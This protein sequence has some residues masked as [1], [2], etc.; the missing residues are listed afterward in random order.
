MKCALITGITG[1]DGSYLTELLLEKG[2]VV[3]GIIRRAS[4]F[5][6]DRIEHL[7]QDIHSCSAR[8]VLHYGDLTDGTGL[9]RLLEQVSPQEVY[10]LGAQSHVRIS[11]DQ[12]EYTA[13]AVAVGTLRL[14]EAVRDF[15]QRTGQKIKYYQAGSS[16]MFG[17]VKEIPQQE[18]TPFYPRSPYGV[19][20]VFAHWQTINYREAY[21]LFACNGILF[22]HESP[23]RGETF[24]TRKITRAAARI[25]LGLQE[26]LYLGNLEA[27]RDWGFAGDYVEAMWRMLQQAE[28]DDYII[29]TG[30]THSVR[31]FLERVFDQLNLKWQDFVEKDERYFRPTEV[32]ILLGDASKAKRQLG[33]NPTVSLEQLVIMMVEHDLELARQEKTLKDAGHTTQHRRVFGK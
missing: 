22:N 23:R 4:T 32:D 11:F 20:K 21:G 31:E 30:K 27:K 5:N 10:N 3:H 15:E 24:V 18:T 14:L 7:Y 26:K 28:P 25:K 19:A 6:T 13:D 1:Q 9:R 2:Y 17:K 16:E 8:L 12:P 29:A 33:W